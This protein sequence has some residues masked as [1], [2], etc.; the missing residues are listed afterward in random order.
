MAALVFAYTLHYLSFFI[1]PFELLNLTYDG[2]IQL[3]HR[4][5]CWAA[6]PLLFIAVADVGLG[7]GL[8]WN[9]GTCSLTVLTGF[10]LAVLFRVRARIICH[11]CS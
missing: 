5:N 7:S 2:L 3:G 6:V 8:F 10:F 4:F 11:S 1:G 9:R